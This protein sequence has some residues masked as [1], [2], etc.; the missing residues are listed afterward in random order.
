MHEHRFRRQVIADV[1]ARAAAVVMLGFDWAHW[2]L[3][4]VL[5][6]RLHGSVDRIAI[7]ELVE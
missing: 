5:E 4:N 7:G 2:F 3:P 1:T 6:I